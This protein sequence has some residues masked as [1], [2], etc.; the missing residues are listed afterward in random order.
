MARSA[1]HRLLPW[2]RFVALAIGLLVCGV[3]VFWAGLQVGS[4]Q[5]DPAQ[6]ASAPLTVTVETASVGRSLTLPVVVKQTR[7]PV[8]GNLAAGVLTKLGTPGSYASGDVLYAV[9]GRDIYAAP[10]K[11]P[12]YRP[13]A[14]DTKGDDVLALNQ[15]LVDLGYLDYADDKFDVY[16]E[17]AVKR[18]QRDAGKEPT[19]TIARGEL[20]AIPT[21][22]R[23]IYFDPEIGRVGTLLSEGQNLVLTLTGDPEFQLPLTDQ[24]RATVLSGMQVAVTDGTN[25]WPAVIGEQGTPSDGVVPYLLTA[26]DGGTVCGNQCNLLPPEP[27]VSLL[28]EVEIVPQQ[29][30]LAVPLAALTLGTDGT[31]T[32]T[33]QEAGGPRQTQVQVLT[34]ADGVALVSGLAAGDVVVLAGPQS[35]P[36]P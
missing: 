13:L 29:E 33:V 10:G 9:D 11:T 5:Q 22:P 8:G 17:D 3:A 18:W 6:A 25:T 21:L 28:G 14:K 32:V 34:V 19:G 31:A 24:Q 30:G 20:V 4:Q 7:V 12:F 27:T 1:S 26:P 2:Q 23:A 16:T 36:G 35:T 15:M